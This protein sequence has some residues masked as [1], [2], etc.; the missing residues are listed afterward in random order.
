MTDE[1]ALI[2]YDGDCIFCS[3]YARLVRLRE[4]VGKVELLD[5]RS[6]DPRIAT[7]W[8]HGYDLNEG[9]LFVYGGRVHHGADAM[10]V[11]ASLSGSST[12]FS[13]LNRSILSNR[14][15]ATLLYPLLKLGRRVTLLARGK[16]LMAR[17]HLDA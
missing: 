14:V 9:M 6:D 11:L 7:Y 10:H 17:P 1:A 12:W 15:T 16:S 4:T 8:R 2:I 13:R 5:A 3:N